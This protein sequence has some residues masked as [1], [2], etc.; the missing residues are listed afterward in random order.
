MNSY[1]W[2]KISVIVK[3]NDCIFPHNL[4]H[5]VLIV[6]E[7][8][9][10]TTHYRPKPS[11]RSRLKYFGHSVTKPV[12]KPECAFGSSIDAPKIEVDFEFKIGNL[13]ISGVQQNT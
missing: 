3:Q 1:G 5:T 6:V 2:T 4:T 7:N 10:Y 8:L 12:T 11:L 13:S 9:I